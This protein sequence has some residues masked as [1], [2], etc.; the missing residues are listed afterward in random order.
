MGWRIVGKDDGEMSDSSVLACPGCGQKNRVRGDA[1]G[2]PHCGKCGR[3][4]PWLAETHASDFEALV[5]KAP[6]PVLIDFWAP[7]CGPCRIVAPAVDSLSKELAGRLKVVKLN[8][9]DE[10]ALGQRFG[11]R[12]IPTL[13]LMEGGKER[14][15]VVGAMNVNALRTWVEA[16]LSSAADKPD[17]GRR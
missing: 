3:P 5:E 17:R 10:P 13:I 2:I 14:D 9:D 7:W 6:I 4:L 1:L 8:T 16:R 15:R 11:V 12:S